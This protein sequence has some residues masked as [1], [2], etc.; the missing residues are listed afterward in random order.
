MRPLQDSFP[1]RKLLGLALLL[2][3]GTLPGR[4]QVLARPGWAGSGVAPEAWWRRAVFYRL[5]PAR[6]QDS[7]ADGKGDLQ[8]LIDRLD[9]IQSLGVDALLLDGTLNA[10]GDLGD[11][12]RAASQRQLRVLMRLPA[13]TA[14]ASRPDTLHTVQTWMG[15]G[16]AGIWAPR[17]PSE[18]DYPGLLTALGSILHNYAGERVLLSDP[19]PVTLDPPSRAS[20]SAHRINPAGFNAQRGGQLVT[21][22][23]FSG[24]SASS[25]AL[26]P[27]LLAASQEPTTGINPLLEA[28]PGAQTGSPD[29]LAEAT[30]LLI[31]RGA[32][33]FNFGEEIG[34]QL[35]PAHPGAPLPVMQWTPSNHTPPPPA[36]TSD[37]TPAAPAPEFGAYHPYVP[38]PR[39]LTGQ[40]AS[41]VHVIAD[42]N[43]PAKLP[44]PDTLPGYTAGD[45]PSPP[46]EGQ[47][48]NITTQDRDPRSLLN[49]VRQLIAMHHGNPT[50]RNGSQQ[51]LSPE[52]RDTLV[53][54]RRA[55]AG[56]RIAANL[57]AG[58]NLSDRPVTL[59]LDRE[60]ESS[61]MR[62]GL[63]RPLLAS[64]PSAE[65]G[66]TTTHLL[67]PPHGVLVGEIFHSG[68][69]SEAAE[70][71]PR[72]R[73][74]RRNRR[75][76]R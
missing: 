61:G 18:K 67:L 65:T 53:W 74:G 44:D 60:L 46:S 32:V 59:D 40:P 19:A 9:Y 37:A 3:F 42:A 54:V 33:I 47:Q 23:V 43:I 31:S 15:E 26:R 13:Q 75:V 14:A 57:V 48:R 64:N 66:E 27:G 62:G 2:A 12:V 20:R 16:I 4:P 63:L 34:L 52:S 73:S 8:G 11:V 41:S 56:S 50:V 5:D 35:Y 1:T 25:E 24:A 45:L 58:L 29:A 21:T 38:P 72:H 28:D 10:P 39:G 7:D 51:A 49:A 17:D 6:F 30:L 22:A 36:A 71:A 68:S 70:P 76:R 69:A 55:P